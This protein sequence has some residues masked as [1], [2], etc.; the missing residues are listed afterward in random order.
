MK[1][2]FLL[3]LFIAAFTLVKA[4]TG[5]PAEEPLRLKET[6]HNFGKIAQHKPVYYSF[7]ISNTGTSPLKLDNV[8]ATCGCTTPEWSREPIAP[9]AS[10]F[11]KVGY[12]AAAEGAFEKYITI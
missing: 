1:K 7:E 12:N 6:E 4:Q 2:S 8:Q 11:I 3:L 5:G 10:A 9:G